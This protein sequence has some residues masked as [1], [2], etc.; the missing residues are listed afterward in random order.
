MEAGI[1]DNNFFDVLKEEIDE[2]RAVLRLARAAARAPQNTEIFTET[3]QQFVQ[4]KREEMRTALMTGTD[5]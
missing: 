5:R 3:L 1:R 2:G 4:M